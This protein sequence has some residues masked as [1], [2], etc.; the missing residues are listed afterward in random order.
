AL[1]DNGV[2][3]LGRTLAR[4]PVHPRLARLLVEGHRLGVLDRAALAAALLSERDPFVRS[5]ESPGRQVGRAATASDV[6]DRVEALEEYEQ[7][8]RTEMPMGHVNRTS[9]RF[10]LRARDQ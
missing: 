4:L 10:V 2:T 5:A 1:D 6:L 9:A 8:G 7:H 3:P